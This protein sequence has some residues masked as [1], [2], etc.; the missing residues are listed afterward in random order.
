MPMD[1]VIRAIEQADS[2]NIQDILQIAIRRYRDL[3]PQWRMMFISADRNAM[4]ENS[5]KLMELIHQ[6]DN[7]FAP[8][9]SGN[10][11]ENNQNIL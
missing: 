9:T 7:I 2:E 6:A 1:E 11:N 8:T 3:Y 5:Q 10:I 4:D